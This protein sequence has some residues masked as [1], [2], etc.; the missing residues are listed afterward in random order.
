M[1]LPFSWRVKIVD[2][3]PPATSQQY[4][5]IE[6]MIRLVKE[7]C[8]RGSFSHQDSTILVGEK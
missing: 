7:V 3:L 5:I 2:F 6:D 1:T 8:L 4:Q